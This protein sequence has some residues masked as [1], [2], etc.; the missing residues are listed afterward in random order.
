VNPHPDGCG[1]VSYKVKCHLLLDFRNAFNQLLQQDL[2][3]LKF[4]IRN[5]DGNGNGSS[6]EKKKGILKLFMPRPKLQKTKF[7]CDSRFQHAFTACHCVFKVITLVS[8]KQGNYFE[9][10]NA[11]SKRLLKTSVATQ[12]NEYYF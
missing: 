4:H 3:K 10:A 6:P 8:A 9:N 12:L 1:Y 7:R 5:K 11:C 2:C